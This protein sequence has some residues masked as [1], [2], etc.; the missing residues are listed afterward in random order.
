M[1]IHELPR[2]GGARRDW[3]AVAVSVGLATGCIAWFAARTRTSDEPARLTEPEISWLAGPVI[4]QPPVH[5]AAVASLD[6]DDPVIG[7]EVGGRHRAYR[8]DALAPIAGHVVNDRLSNVPLVVTYCDRTN[9]VRVF[10]GPA[11]GAGLDTTVA[12]WDDRPGEHGLLLRIGRAVYHQ[13][14][15]APLDGRSAPFP[16]AAI[17]CERTTWAHWHHVHPDTDLYEGSLPGT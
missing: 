15:G 13:S 3:C 16:F 2:R 14:T 17:D 1:R 12:G 9:C 6:G 5:A 8:L 7:V 10:A 4:E 11:G